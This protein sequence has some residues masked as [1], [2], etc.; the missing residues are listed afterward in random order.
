MLWA[1]QCTVSIIYQKMSSQNSFSYFASSHA[2]PFVL[3]TVAEL[4]DNAHEVLRVTA[5]LSHYAKC[6]HYS[7]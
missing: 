7:K 5:A 3:A 2:A 4:Q 1:N 6:V